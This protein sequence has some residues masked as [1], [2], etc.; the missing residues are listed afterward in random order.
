MKI[1]IVTDAWHPQINGV[2]TTLSKV[3][4]LLEKTGH[5]VI[6]ITPEQFKT[7]PCPTYRSIPLALFPGRKMAR[8]LTFISPDAIHIATEGP[9]GL[10]ARKYCVKHQVPFTSSYHTQFP[11]YVNMR[12]G[13]PV[14]WLYRWM[15]WFHGGAV[16]TLVTTYSMRNRLLTEGFKHLKV[17]SR[18][19]DSSLFYPRKNFKLES[20]KPIAM[21]MGRVAQEKSIED[22]L[23][24]DLPVTK[25]VVGDG[26]DRQRLE[27]KYPEAIFVGFKQGDELAEYLSAADVFVFPSTTDTFGI[28]LIE[29]L[30]CGI[31]VAAYPVQG[32]ID[33][34][35]QGVTGVMDKDLG[36][37]VVA[38]LE[39]D[40]EN[41]IR[42][43]KTFNWERCA[44]QFYDWLEPIPGKP[45]RCSRQIAS[46]T[47]AL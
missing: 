2:V 31:P 27:E 4:G 15:R 14:S 21:Y 33:V 25:Y 41:C 32:P 34:L 43:A 23:R 9:L 7:V 47:A 1:V 19:V 6:F 37:A 20:D 45:G 39:L 12:T 42:A 30:A 13:I 46:E 22:F 3:G 38:A 11:E 17:W 35:E 10:A 24:L 36:K 44:E 16:N 8:K 28:V 5:D 40:P 26:P 18:G 29:A